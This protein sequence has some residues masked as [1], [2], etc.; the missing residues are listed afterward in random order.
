MVGGK[1]DVKAVNGD[2]QC[3]CAFIQ[4]F[5]IYICIYIF[6]L[7]TYVLKNVYVGS[8]W[9]SSVHT[10]L[11]KAQVFSVRPWFLLPEGFQETDIPFKHVP[12]HCSKESVY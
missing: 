9:R 7:C 11:C 12:P 1:Y 4:C 6:V 3:L 8:G 5:H 2:M 10:R